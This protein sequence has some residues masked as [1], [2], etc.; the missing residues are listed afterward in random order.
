MSK[1]N[2]FLQVD[3]TEKMFS[4]PRQEGTFLYFTSTG[5]NPNPSPG[6]TGIGE[7]ENLYFKN[8]AGLTSHIVNAQFNE[9]VFIKDAYIFWENAK[10]G[11]RLSLSIILPANTPYL[12]E[13]GAGNAADDGNGNI[14]NITASPYP[15]ETWI[16]SHILFPIEITLMRFINK[17]N[18]LGTNHHGVVLESPDTAE[19]DDC[20]EF[21]LLIESP[22]GNTELTVSM[23]AELYRVNTI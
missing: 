23:M 16:G 4:S 14:V 6:T 8:S 22:S 17:I 9:T 13:D 19:M 2:R 21:R 12:K 7:G 5:D 18:L 3:K 11:D 1:R 20:L 15:D 10:L